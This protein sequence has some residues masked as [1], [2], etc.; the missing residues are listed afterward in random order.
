MLVQ[1]TQAEYTFGPGL[2][3]HP[4]HIAAISSHIN[5]NMVIKYDDFKDEVVELFEEYIPQSKGTFRLTRGLGI[6]LTIFRLDRGS[7]LFNFSTFR[8]SQRE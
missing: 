4:H 3:T 5:R 1:S 7:G 8:L 6:R 2:D